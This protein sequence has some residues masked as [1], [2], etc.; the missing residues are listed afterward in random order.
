MGKGSEQTL[1]PRG[2]T[3]GKQIH[4]KFLNIPSYQGNANQ[5]HNEIPFHSSQ[6]VTINRRSNTNVGE[7]A[8]KKKPLYTAGGTVNW[9]S[10]SEKEYGGSSKN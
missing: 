4:E 6:K 5:N 2:H 3:N 7:D 8:E 9:Y 10:H 1:L